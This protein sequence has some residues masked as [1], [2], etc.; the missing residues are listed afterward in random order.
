MEQRGRIA[1]MVAA[2]VGA[3]SAC[4][5]GGTGNV[6]WGNGGATT[7]TTSTQATSTKT[8]TSSST[9]SGST[10]TTSSSTT[11]TTTTTSS[12]DST[13]ST[14][15][16]TSSTASTTSTTTV[17]TNPC[18]SS[19][20]PAELCDPAHIG[21]DDNCDGRVDED[22][23]CEPGSV[24]WCFKGDPAY[25][26]TSGCHDG[27]ERC[28]KTEVYGD[29]T[30]G[31]HAT[32]ADQCFGTD[33]LPGCHALSARPFATV[34][35]KPGTGTFSADAAPGSEV[36]QVSCPEGIAPCPGVS[37]LDQFQPLQSGEYSVRYTKLAAGGGSASCTF[38]LYVGAPGLRVELSWNFEAVGRTDLDLHLHRPGTTSDWN[39]SDDCYYRTC[40]LVAF[41]G[42][43][44][45]ET[46]SWFEGPPAAP[47]SPVNWYRD[48]S[49]ENNGCYFA[50]RGVGLKWQQFGRGCHNPRLDLDNTSCTASKT[51]PSDA[52]FCAPE[53]INIDFPPMNSWMRVAVDRHPLT[54]TMETIRPQ[55]KVY[56]DGALAADLGRSGYDAPVTMRMP[57]TPASASLG[58]ARLWLV[59]DVRFTTDSCGRRSCTVR[60]LYADPAARAALAVDNLSFGPPYPADP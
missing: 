59:G 35:L 57:G 47:P 41:M 27:V 19:C 17:T 39:T 3:A 18:A 26:G 40:T 30:G 60:P 16:T 34:A 10:T 22:C 25:R 43:P 53:N 21:L 23:A 54:S 5:D 52:D 28:Q 8:S 56:C 9:S 31:N 55:V 37:G 15:T 45:T 20:G 11:S 50:P 4:F 58:D 6:D 29:C 36:F 49:F 42:N 33:T 24:H 38:P 12:T 13:T 48:P 2:L 7:T 51:N 32:A 1:F 14:T 44:A 46:A